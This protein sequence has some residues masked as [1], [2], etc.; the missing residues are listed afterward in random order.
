MVGLSL[1]IKIQP[2]RILPNLLTSEDA[3]DN[4]AWTKSLTTVTANS[5]AAPDGS[6]TADKV[7][8]TAASGG[9]IVQQFA[10]L[11]SGQVYTQSFRAKAGE[12]TAFRL[13]VS[14]AAGAGGYSFNLSTGATAVTTAGAPTG[15]SMTDLGGGWWL[16][17]MQFVPTASGNYGAALYLH[18][19]AG[20]N[21]YLGDG[22]SGL[23]LW[24]GRLVAGVE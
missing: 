23:Y 7:V 5:I 10:A 20:T 4:A 6:T 16:C 2:K 13:L 17:K 1:G 19:A 12:R 24:R 3:F 8:E 14:G 21:N 11:V 9:H 18:N 15:A 22:A